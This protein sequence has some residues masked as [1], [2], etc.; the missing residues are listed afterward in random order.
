MINIGSTIR[1]YRRRKNLSQSQ[2][3]Q[4]LHISR[5]TISKW[6]LDKSLP[7]IEY[8][9]LLGKELDVSLD[10]LVT[11]K[12]KRERGGKEMKAIML[13]QSYTPSD[14][15]GWGNEAKNY[16]V[17]NL[18]ANLSKQYPKFE[19][20]AAKFS[21]LKEIFSQEHIDFILVLPESQRKLQALKEI[22]KGEIR[23][24]RSDEYVEMTTNHIYEEK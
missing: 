24:I 5:Q 6:E 10:Q 12:K 14:E 1:H 17:L 13:V 23:T 16:G 8:L 18:I 3:A 2:L 20:R 7:T 4:K 21:E 22:F 9:I 19:W 15:E 11:E